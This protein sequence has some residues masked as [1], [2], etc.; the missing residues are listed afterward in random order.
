MTLCDDVS[1]VTSAIWLT[2]VVVFMALEAHCSQNARHQKN[3]TS[4]FYS[5]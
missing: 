4:Y 3:H 2:L 1:G 5:G